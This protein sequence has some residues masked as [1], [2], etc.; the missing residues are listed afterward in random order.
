MQMKWLVP[1]LVRVYRD[2]VT[3]SPACGPLRDSLSAMRDAHSEYLKSVESCEDGFRSP[4]LAF[5]T[6]LGI[7][8]TAL[9]LASIA[10]KWAQCPKGGLVP[11][12]LCNGIFGFSSYKPKQE[13][14]HEIVN[15][16][17]I[18]CGSCLY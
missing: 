18:P 7:A 12:D 6:G 4:S 9:A 2:L 15:P 3:R 10:N 14:S 1:V 16:S 8:G 13:Q 11:C 5:N 17:A